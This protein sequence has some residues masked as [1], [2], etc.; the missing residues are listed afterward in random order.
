MSG[1][2]NK[3]ID[4]FLQKEFDSKTEIILSKEE[5]YKLL[6]KF[7]KAKVK[8]EID[9]EK[10]KEY[11]ELFPNIK[12]PTGKYGRSSIEVVTKCFEWFFTTYSTFDWEV[13]LRATKLYISEYERQDYNFMRTSH[14]FILK[15]YNN[16]K[17]FSDLAEYCDRIINVPQETIDEYTKVRFHEK[18]R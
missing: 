11:N 12:L 3:K 18:I 17:P 8:L 13:V 4:D 1:K 14:Y 6:V 7:S 5:L 2:I 16:S 9:P 15:Y 10:V